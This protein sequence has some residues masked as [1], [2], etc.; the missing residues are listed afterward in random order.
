MRRRPRGRPLTA[1]GAALV[2][3]RGG[4]VVVGG[5][6]HAA[7][8]CTVVYGENDWGS[9]FTAFAALERAAGRRPV[10]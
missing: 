5:P 7:V 9:G 4:P 1:V 10:R 6:A 2:M 8:A 3:L